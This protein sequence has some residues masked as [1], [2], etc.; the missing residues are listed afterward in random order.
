[1]WYGMHGMGWGMG[2]GWVFGILFFAVLAALFVWIVIRLA[3]M[4]RY[5]YKDWHRGHHEDEALD[6]LKRRY[7]KGEISKKEFEEMKRDLS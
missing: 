4:S 7:A 6:I 1:M 2:F 5:G 3:R